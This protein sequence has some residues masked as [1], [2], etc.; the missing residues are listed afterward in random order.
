M[1]LLR[2]VQIS[3]PTASDCPCENVQSGKY[4][5]DSE[6]WVDRVENRKSNVDYYYC[7]EQVNEFV[8]RPQI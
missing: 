5:N 4:E 3:K 1:L 6:K 2:L 8:D 7:N